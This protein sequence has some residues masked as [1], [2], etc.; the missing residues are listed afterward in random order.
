MA[1]DSDGKRTLDVWDEDGKIEFKDSDLA[2]LRLLPKVNSLCIATNFSESGFAELRGL[3]N[4]E[5]IDIGTDVLVTDKVAADFATM[6]NLRGLTIWQSDDHSGGDEKY[7]DDA[8]LAALRPLK[9]LRS[10]TLYNVPITAN[11]MQV[12]KDFPEL[13]EFRL[14]STKL[15]WSELSRIPRIPKLETLEFGA[16][17]IVP[18]TDNSD[19]EQSAPVT[20]ASSSRAKKA[21][22]SLLEHGNLSPTAISWLK[23][24]TEWPPNIDEK[25]YIV[26][27]KDDK[28]SDGDLASLRAMPD[29]NRIWIKHAFSENGLAKLH[30][31]A[32]IEYLS[33]GPE[34]RVTDRVVSDIASLE[35]LRE[36]EIDRQLPIPGDCKDCIDDRALAAL[37]R[38]PKLRV[39]KIGG[40]TITNRGLAKL[41]DFPK[42]QELRLASSKLTWDCL[43][44]F[45]LP[46]SLITLDLSCP[47][48]GP[49]RDPRQK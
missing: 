11:G 28:L 36:L 8:G 1:A 16:E 48:A 32:S 35:N 17:A 13:R 27:S 7:L 40:T 19:D 9:R 46:R 31:L 42:L 33:I 39:L 37:S 2:A 18:D 47:P 41:K 24:H 25:H 43:A 10:L 49:V 23:H 14:A 12:L 6:S 21:E 20:L 5:Y 4:I 45:P 30:G 44:N 22:A 34:A 3:Q 26:I 29:V 38:L 15:T